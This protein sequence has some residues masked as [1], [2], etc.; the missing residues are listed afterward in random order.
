MNWDDLRHAVAA[1]RHGTATAAGHALSV[2]PV[3]VS[4]RIASLEADLG[5]SLFVRSSR[6]LQ[7]TAAFDA[8]LPLAEGMQDL[9]HAV[10]RTASGQQQSLGGIVRLACPADLATSVV[11]P[12][13]P[14]LARRAPDLQLQ[15]RTGARVLDLS[16]REA[17]VSLRLVR[18]AHVDLVCRRLGELAYAVYGASDRTSDRWIAWDVSVRGIEEATWIERALEGEA[19]ALRVDRTAAA[20]AAAAAGLGRA[21]LPCGLA[22]ET[23]GLCRLGEV[24]L[25]RTLWLVTH[26][27][28]ARVPRVRVVVEHLAQALRAVT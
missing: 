23:P 3:T 5:V 16:R 15:I 27:D 4:R 6:G 28:L 13:L 18:P 26:R 8:L 9:A 14:A 21:L 2:D 12:T 22:D 24:V 1:A 20:V 11:I 25:T 19:P 10:E 17:D 7:P